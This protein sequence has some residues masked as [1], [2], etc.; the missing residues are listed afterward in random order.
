[1][2]QISLDFPIPFL[3]PQSSGIWAAWQA[4]HECN[5]WEAEWS[6]INPSPCI[7]FCANGHSCQISRFIDKY[8]IHTCSHVVPYSC[9]FEEPRFL[10]FADLDSFRFRL[11]FWCNHTAFLDC[12]ESCGL[13]DEVRVR[14]F[15]APSVEIQGACASTIVSTTRFNDGSCSLSWETLQGYER[16]KFQTPF[17]AAIW[18]RLVLVFSISIFN[19]GCW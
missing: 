5:Y 8:V 11:L 16:P 19:A 3:C 7:V 13:A 6:S 2:E 15:A 10:R 1:M 12:P 4:T 17:S 18:T 14:W 9:S